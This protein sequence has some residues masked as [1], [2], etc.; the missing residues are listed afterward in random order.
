M[1]N[2]YP[3]STI[4]PIFQ[5]AESI[6]LPQTQ[7]KCCLMLVSPKD[8]IRPLIVSLVSTQSGLE[9]RRRHYLDGTL[10][11]LAILLMVTSGDIDTLWFLNKD[12]YI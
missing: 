9:T 3:C 11:R 7:R 12:I 10:D 2:K 4:R 1:H 8:T 5:P 6:Y